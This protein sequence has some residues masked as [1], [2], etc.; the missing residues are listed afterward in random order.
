MKNNLTYYQHYV[1]SHAHWKFKLLR[2]KLGWEGEGRFW[3]L[4]NMIGD[5]E[6]CILKLNKKPLKASVITDLG[7]TEKEFDE[8]LK[9]LSQE[10][11]LI[12]WLDGSITTEIV[13]ENLKKV[14]KER[15][16]ARIRKLKN[17]SQYDNEP[18]LFSLSAKN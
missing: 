9:I 18:P 15:D 3:A 10:C 17:K 16:A 1:N 2:S 8:F 13:R 4:N 7:M 6:N 11:E 14:M 12:I 5:S